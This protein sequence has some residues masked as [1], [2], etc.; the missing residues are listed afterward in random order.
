MPPRPDAPPTP[1]E[2]LARIA[3]RGRGVRHPG[4][5]GAGAFDALFTRLSGS[6]GVQAWGDAAFDRYFGQASHTAA[7]HVD[8]LIQAAGIDARS[9]V[10]DLGCGTGGIACYVAG[11]AGAR[12]VGVDWSR[13]AVRLARCR[14]AGQGLH[15]RASFRRADL[16]ALQVR[17]AS[18]DAV[19]AVDVAYFDVDIGTLAGLAARALHGRGTCVALVTLRNSPHGPRAPDGTPRLPSRAE[20][21]QAFADAGFDRTAAIDLTPSYGKLVRRMAEL[22]RAYL[23]RLRHELGEELA[24]ARLAEDSGLADLLDRGAVSRFLFTARRPAS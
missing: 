12:V 4:R 5:F 17:P 20:I 3:P 13:V 7:E 9:R 2:P 23:P 8:L 22:W 19:L 15:A 1:R 16:G 14:A 24:S 21:H 11:H 18:Y 10:L 6:G